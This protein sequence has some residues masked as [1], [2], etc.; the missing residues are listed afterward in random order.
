MDEIK[1]R[2]YNLDFKNPHVVPDEPGD[3][4]VLLAELD[5]AEEDAAR[6]SSKL[7][8]ILEYALL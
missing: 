5:A 7:K 4:S 1:A 6:F 8:S 2:N 3:P